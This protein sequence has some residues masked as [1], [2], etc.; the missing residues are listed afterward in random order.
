[1]SSRYEYS[2][3]NKTGIVDNDTDAH[4]DLVANPG[5]TMFVYIER[6]S[7]SV[8]VAAAGGGGIAEVRDTDGN[9]IKTINVD[10]VKD[11]VFDWGDEG[12]KVGPNVGIQV[13]VSGAQTKQA[14]VSVA[15]AGH[16]AFR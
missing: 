6:L 12:L 3:V 5:S 11:V 2:Q 1:M 14:S 9:I 16:L 10:G 4:I 13:S 7:L 15:L 8:F